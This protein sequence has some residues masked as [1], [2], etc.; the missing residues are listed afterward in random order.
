MTLKPWYTVVAPREDLRQQKPLDAAEFAVHLDQVRDGRAPSVYQ[1][2][3]EFFDRTY[4]TRKLLELGVEVVRRLSGE[5]NEASAVFNLATQFGGGKTHALTM[6]YHLAEHGQDAHR[7][8]GVS[9]IVDEAHVPYVPKAATAVFVGQQFDSLRGRGGKDGTPFRRTPWGEIAYQLGGEEAF[10]VVAQHDAEGIAPGGDAIRDLLPS[11]RPCLIL[12]D[13]LVNYISRHR[14]SGLSAQLYNFM[15]NLSEEARSQRNVVLAVSIPASELEMTAED[16]HDYQSLKKL[17]DRLGKPVIISSEHETSEIIRRRLFEWQGLNKDAEKTIAA[18]AAWI[19]ENGSH[20]SEQYNVDVA[21][22]AFEATYPFHP[23]VLSVFERKWQALPRFQRTRGVLQLLARWVSKAYHEGYANRQGDPLIDLGTAPLEDSDFRA[24]VYEQLGEGR[25]EAAITTDIAGRFNSHAI[26]LDSEAQE[27]LKKARLHRKVAT[28]VFFESNGGQTR[29]EASVPEIRF[30]AG[31]P[32]LDIGNIETALDTLSQTCHYLSVERSRYRFSLRPNLIKM[33]SDYR[34]N[35]AELRVTERVQQEIQRAFDRSKAQAELEMGSVINVVL[36]PD[37]SNSIPNIPELTLVVLDPSYSIND[38]Q[39][40]QMVERMTWEYGTSSRTFKNALIWCIADDATIL[41]DNAK[42]T[43]AWEDIRDEI[44]EIPYA[45]DTPDDAQRRQMREYLKKSA[46]DLRE[47]V[48]R[49]YR[50]VVLLNKDGSLSVVNLG[51]VHSSSATTIINLVIN[52]LQQQGDI[53]TTVGFNFLIR[54]WPPAFQEWDIRSV[55]N[56][57]FASPQ[58]PRL[59]KPEAIRETIARGVSEGYL[60]YVSRLQ[61]NRYTEFKYKQQLNSYDVEISDEMCIITSET[62]EIYE[63][64]KQQP[65]DEV[66]GEYVGTSYDGNPDVDGWEVPVGVSDETEETL[67]QQS[68]TLKWRGEIPSQKWTIFYN[69]ILSR[70]AVNQGLRLKVEF[71]VS[72]PDG[73][74]SQKIEETKL[75]LREIGLDDN[76]DLG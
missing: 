7:W 40:A 75:S 54:N 20:L 49:T 47:A 61:N 46:S 62:A 24:A 29:I 69:K 44:E 35:I 43:L 51:L 33:H 12:I 34:A 10:A 26:S 71:E 14:K 60:A 13:E 22:E 3:D 2:P 17:L 8:R 76:V 11:D 56:A 68:S 74:S 18:Y 36:L 4:L 31:F 57:F 19:S 64:A 30:A 55:R 42:K 72:P 70:F 23:T 48:W 39:T 73:I 9:R 67:D 52:R 50:N 45:D 59:L 63:A 5:I 58:F 65:M 66:V 32:G 37:D 25:L 15:Q 41:R 38:Q 21:R 27:T 28:T 6:L 16:E 1:N 53:E